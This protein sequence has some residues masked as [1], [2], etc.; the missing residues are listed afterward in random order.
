M[1]SKEYKDI[2]DYFK[3]THFVDKSVWSNKFDEGLY[4]TIT[5]SDFD[6]EYYR[7]LIGGIAD[8][9]DWYCF[10]IKIVDER[11]LRNLL[12]VLTTDGIGMYST[13]VWEEPKKSDYDIAERINR[14]QRYF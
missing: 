13:P 4:N 6:G 3:F 5:F 14:I 12:E 9:D 10:E 8:G 1:I 2:L 7:I 11:Q